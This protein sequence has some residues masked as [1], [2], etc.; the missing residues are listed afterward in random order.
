MKEPI[1]PIH[2]SHRC[3][4][5]HKY[6]NSTYTQQSAHLVKQ[7]KTPMQNVYLLVQKIN[8][9]ALG[10]ITVKYISTNLNS[11]F[12][13]LPTTR[14]EIYLANKA[15]I[16]ENFVVKVNGHLQVHIY[17]LGLIENLD[18]FNYKINYMQIPISVTNETTSYIKKLFETKKLYYQ[19][20]FNIR[21]VININCLTLETIDEELENINIID[22][23]DEII[24][25][26]DICL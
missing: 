16:L 7:D 11:Q 1:R 12:T 10:F 17:W 18:I 21:N 8:G 3:V 13:H 14:P 20:K 19:S 9:S 15:N 5:L 2:K 6:V 4:C 24:K 23:L 26:K 22:D 25:I